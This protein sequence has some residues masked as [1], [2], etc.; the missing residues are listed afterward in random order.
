MSGYSFSRK[1]IEVP[2]VKT[3]NRSIQTQIPAPGT[4]DILAKLDNYES[5]SMQGTVPLVWE[6]AQGFNVFDPKGN[7]WIDFTSAIFIANIGH[8]NPRFIKLVRE[9]LDKNLVHH[10]TYPSQIKARY[11]EKLVQFT[12]GEF[13]KAFLLSG[14]TEATEAALKLMRMNGQRIGKKRLGII[15]MEGSF[16]GRTMGA[17]FLGGIQAQKEWIGYVDKDIFHVRFPYPWILEEGTSPEEFFESELKVLENNG[18]CLETDICG[19][20]FEV[21]Q[22]WASLF[23]PEGFMKAVE[24]FCRTKKILLTMDEVQSGFARTG[25]KFGYQH[26][27]IHPDLICC[28]KGMGSGVALSGVLGKREIMDI[29]DVGMMSSTNSANPIA[30]AG[31][32]ATLEEILE[33]NLVGESHRKGMLFLGG[34][35][36][37]KEKYPERI[38]YVFGKGMIASVLFKNPETGEADS[39][40]S[41]RVAESCMQKGLLV[42]HTGR[43]SV[44]MGPPLTIP[45]EALLEGLDVLDEAI[46]ECA[47]TTH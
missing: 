23:Y 21:F 14:G 35:N 38:S 13:D 30:C 44:K 3:K 5:R 25:V 15:S 6:R 41:S 7:K 10:F 9:A 12:D 39:L 4:E 27:G 46:V 22:G 2:L 20:I 42:V 17:Q 32:L 34:L 18:V 40:F 19:V 29:P 33:N 1:P 47:R 45:D 43:E 28:G 37:L 31:G 26:Y 36:K 11:Y 8:S 24:S 16:H